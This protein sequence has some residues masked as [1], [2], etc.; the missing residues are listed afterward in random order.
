MKI[1]AIVVVAVCVAPFVSAWGVGLSEMADQ[2]SAIN[3][4]IAGR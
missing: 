1:I 2:L 4:I 3:S